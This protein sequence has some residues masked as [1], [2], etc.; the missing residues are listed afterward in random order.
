M[1]VIMEDQKQLAKSLSELVSQIEATIPHAK[2]LGYL[3]VSIDISIDVAQEL[4]EKLALLDSS[5]AKQLAAIS[6]N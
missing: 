5:Y 4:V 6:P 2:N 3:G 1:A